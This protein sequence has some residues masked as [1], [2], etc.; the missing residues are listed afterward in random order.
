MI[1]LAA[2]FRNAKFNLEVVMS[3]SRSVIRKSCVVHATAIEIFDTIGKLRDRRDELVG[4][5]VSHFRV[6]CF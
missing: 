5:G 6:Y 2:V 1:E 4:E 3:R